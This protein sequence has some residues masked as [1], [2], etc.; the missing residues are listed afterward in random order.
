MSTQPPRRM[1]REEA[2]P[3]VE[4]LMNPKT[5]EEKF[6]EILVA[7]KQGLACPHI[8]DYIFWSTD[9]NLTPEKVVDRAMTYKAIAL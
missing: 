5:P 9:P 8:S 6:S 2:I 4:R 3:L 1:T 7:L